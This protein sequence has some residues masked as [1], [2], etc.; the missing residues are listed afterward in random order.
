MCKYYA[1]ANCKGVMAG[2]YSN[3][4]DVSPATV[5]HSQVI[6]NPQSF[7]CQNIGFQKPNVPI[8][9]PKPNP[10]AAPGYD[11]TLNYYLAHTCAWQEVATNDDC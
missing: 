1:D 11:A 4:L 9:V 6:S 2:P 8:K 3:E 5:F 10:F 7:F